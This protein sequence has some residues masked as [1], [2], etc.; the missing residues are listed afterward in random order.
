MPGQPLAMSGLE[1]ARASEHPLGSSPRANSP[2]PETPPFQPDDKVVYRPAEAELSYGETA[3]LETV[4]AC[5]W[6]DDGWAWP[7]W[8]VT[9]LA[10]INPETG[11]QISRSAPSFEFRQKTN[12]LDEE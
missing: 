1:A 7:H 9:T 12:E 8:Q 5:D 3:P 6:R 10:G 2:R 4:V 11:F